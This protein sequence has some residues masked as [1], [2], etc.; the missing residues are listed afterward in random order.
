[1]DSISSCHGTTVNAQQKYPPPRRQVGQ[2]SDQTQWR[3]QTGWSRLQ[4]ILERA[5]G[6]QKVLTRHSVLGFT[7]DCE[8]HL[9][10]KRG[11]CMGFWLLRLRASNWL[12]TIHSLRKRQ[13]QIVWCDHKRGSAPSAR[14]LRPRVCWLCQKV[15]D[16]ECGWSLDH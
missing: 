7:R 16:E 3:D 5:R 12:D 10:H 4:R 15:F 11:R 1:M 2:H 6:V 8:W 9:L 13:Q 14:A